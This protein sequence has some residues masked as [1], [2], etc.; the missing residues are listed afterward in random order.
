MIGTITWHIIKGEDEEGKSYMKVGSVVITGIDDAKRVDTINSLFTGIRLDDNMG[1]RE[2]ECNAW[3]HFQDG[4]DLFYA[5]PDGTSASHLP[6]MFCFEQNKL[7][8]HNM[9]E[10]EVKPILHVS[11]LDLLNEKPAFKGIPRYA[12]IMDSSIWN[13]Y[14]NFEDIVFGKDHNIPSWIVSSIAY[15]SQEGYYNLSISREYADLNARLTIQSYLLGANGHGADVSPFLFHSESRIKNAR[16]KEEK[17]LLKLGSVYDLNQYK[18]RILL[19]DDRINESYL[20]PVPD[21]LEL[22]ITKESILIKRIESMFGEGSCHCVYLSSGTKSQESIKGVFNQQSFQ[23]SDPRFVIL[24]VDNICDAEDALK[25]YKF[26]FILLD[27][28]LKKAGDN[29]GGYG[30]TILKDLD[31]KLGK[32]NDNLT[33]YSQY[34]GGKQFIVGPDHRYYFMFISAFTTAISE[35]LR[36]S[37]WSRSEELWHIAEGACPTNTPELF[38]YNLRKMML[39]RIKDSGIEN[40]TPEN[41]LNIVADIYRPAVEGEASV[42]KRANEK[43]QNILRLLY[44]Y[45]R[46]LQDVEMP[47]SGASI[48]T[49]RGSVLMT[50]YFQKYIS[51]GGL[52]EHLVH[53]VHLTAFGT[54]R[55]WPEMWEEYIFFKVQ[56]SDLF[57]KGNKSLGTLF[58]HI[59]DYILELKKL[60]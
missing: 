24:C 53:L 6:P 1:I 30:Y 26:D 57:D 9:R 13:Y 15:N 7:I 51:L 59:E 28:L 21:T 56:F 60:N 25:N 58:G 8:S 44:H 3:I 17:D 40:L 39:K 49:T 23:S 14:L 34:C 31:Q 37:G 16:E 46:I 36:L 45:N 10:E 38:C 12:A 27:Y 22:R 20:T 32:D 43:Y 33:P 5:S 42:R 48:F 2:G 50:S 11:T 4:R 29:D 18:W 55:Q 47:K 19:L 35:R 54:I 41:I 52:L